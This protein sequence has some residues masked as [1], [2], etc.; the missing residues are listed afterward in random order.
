MIASGSNQNDLREVEMPITS[1]TAVKQFYGNAYYPDTMLG[2]AYRGDGK[3]T[4][5]G[6]SGGPLSVSYD[7]V[8]GSLSRLSQVGIASWGYGCGDISLYTRVPAYID[9]I[10]NQVKSFYESKGISY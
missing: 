1:E 2:A 6:D 7:G 4:C 5:L 8:T 9:W 3:D 10:T